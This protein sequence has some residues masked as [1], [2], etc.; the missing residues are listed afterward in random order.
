MITDM[1]AKYCTC[2]MILLKEHKKIK[3]HEWGLVMMRIDDG[4]QDALHESFVRF[5]VDC[6]SLLL[7]VR[8]FSPAL[9]LA[10]LTSPLTLL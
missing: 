6:Y 5:I 4:E 9:A 3:T 2:K 1:K 8:L 7:A 10:P